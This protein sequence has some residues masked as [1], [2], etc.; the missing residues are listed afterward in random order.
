MARW[1]GRAGKTQTN[2]AVNVTAFP[3]SPKLIA[4]AGRPTLPTA[5]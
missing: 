3:I 2:R 1:T 4:D 5:P